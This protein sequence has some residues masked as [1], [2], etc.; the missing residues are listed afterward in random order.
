MGANW[1]AN[2]LNNPTSKSFWVVWAIM[3]VWQN[4]AF[5]F[6]SRAR[7]SGSLSLHMKAALQSNGVWF[8]Q[9]IFVWSAFLKIITGAYGMWKALA[10]GVFYT[11]FTMSGAFLAHHRALKKEKGITAVGANKRY[12]QIPVEEWQAVKATLLGV[13]GPKPMEGPPPP[14]ETL[15]KDFSAAIKA[16]KAK[17][18]QRASGQE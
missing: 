7:N 4:Y 9:S 1:L 3:L 10:A 6:V 16:R 11:I 8:L 18:T 5:T 13:P 14:Q 2:F 15:V 12:A 17:E